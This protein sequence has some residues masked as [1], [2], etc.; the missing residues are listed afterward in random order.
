MDNLIFMILGVL[1]TLYFNILLGGGAYMLLTKGAECLVTT[2]DDKV[3]G[4]MLLL[5]GLILS[6]TLVA[7]DSLLL[8]V[9]GP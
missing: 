8:R 7:M 4:V 2:G 3:A 5:L 1:G 9:L 6:I